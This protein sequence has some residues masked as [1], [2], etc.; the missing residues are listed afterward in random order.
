MELLEPLDARVTFFVSGLSF[1]EEW[2][3]LRPVATHPLVELGGHNWSCFQPELLHRISNKLFGSYNG[4][5]KLQERDARR[6]IKV[7]EDHTGVQVEAWRNHMYMHG[8]FTEAVLAKCGIK[9]ISDGAQKDS[10]GPKW[11]QRGLYHF[12]INVIPDHEH[13]YHAERTPEWVAR[14]RRRYDWSDDWGSGSYFP[15][16][17]ARI[18][19]EDLDRNAEAGIV[20]NVILHP[21][22]MYL[23]DKFSPMR[24]VLEHLRGW[25]F[26]H[27]M[28]V[29]EQQKGLP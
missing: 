14:W 20:S 6:T 23:C 11:D 29:V 25:E 2:S 8:P 27:M 16:D 15:D 3:D 28:E 4:P 10:A 22:T 13:I 9:V 21:I 5:A 26:V 17:W 19:I 7:I 1:V 24:T 12:P 18:A